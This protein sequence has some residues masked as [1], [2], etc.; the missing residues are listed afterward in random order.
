MLH[1]V[2]VDMVDDEVGFEH[3]PGFLGD[4]AHVIKVFERLVPKP[5]IYLLCPEL[6]FTLFDKKFLQLLQGKFPDV[7][8]CRTVHAAKVR[9]KKNLSAVADLKIEKLEN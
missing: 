9:D 6:L 4:V 7:F 5:F 3:F 1:Q 8:L 2:N